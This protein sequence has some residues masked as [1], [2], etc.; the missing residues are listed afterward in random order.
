MSQLFDEDVYKAI[1]LDTCVK[2]RKSFGGPSPDAV[3]VQLDI[4]KEQLGM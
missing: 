3:K 1:S 4:V 2:G